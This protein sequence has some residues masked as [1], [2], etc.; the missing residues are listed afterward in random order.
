VKKPEIRIIHPA[1]SPEY[2]REWK[3]S[4]AVECGGLVFV[5]GCTGSR[6]DGSMPEGVSAQARE[7]FGK[8]GATLRAAGIDFADIVEMTTY[9]VGLGERLDEFRTVRDEFL[10]AGY[11]AWTAVG[12]VELAAAGALLEIRV[13]ARAAGSGRGNPG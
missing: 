4:P 3:F 6:A 1:D 12:V 11:P 5:S 10:P 13:V 7:A 9:H 2:F 8:I